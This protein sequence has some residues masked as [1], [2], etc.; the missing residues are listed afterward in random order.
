[1][2]LNPLDLLF[3]ALPR[4]GVGLVVQGSG[5]STSYQVHLFMNCLV[6]GTQG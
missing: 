2:S 1:M 6:C 4:T 3:D 5:P